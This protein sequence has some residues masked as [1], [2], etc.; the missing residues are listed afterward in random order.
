MASIDAVKHF[1]QLIRGLPAWVDETDVGE[2]LYFARQEELLET[3]EFLIR[4]YE[5][6]EDET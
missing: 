4:Y 5:G 6:G 1:V 3:L 2:V